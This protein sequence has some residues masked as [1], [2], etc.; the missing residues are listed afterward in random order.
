[1]RLSQPQWLM[2]GDC[3]HRIQAEE[4]SGKGQLLILYFTRTFGSII[5]IVFADRETEAQRGPNAV[6]RSPSQ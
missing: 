6:P 1:M 5:V 4:K 2:A 3:C